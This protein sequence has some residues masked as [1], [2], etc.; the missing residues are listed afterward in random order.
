MAYMILARHH[1]R[2]QSTVKNKALLKAAA[3]SNN[4]TL[5]RHYLE[6]TLSAP[7]SGAVPVPGIK[8]VLARKDAASVSESLDNGAQREPETVF[9]ERSQPSFEAP[10]GKELEA[11]YLEKTPVVESV[12]AVVPPLPEATASESVRPN[13]AVAES[14]ASRHPVDSRGRELPSSPASLDTGAV[15]SISE[16]KA[17]QINWF[18]NMRI[19]LRTGKYRSLG[20]RIRASMAQHA[21]QLDMQA[22]EA[23]SRAISLQ[24]ATPPAQE[25]NVPGDL[26]K[27]SVREAA[28]SSI[29]PTGS[30]QPVSTDAPAPGSVDL[31]AT[32]PNEATREDPGRS[33]PVEIRPAS[34]DSVMTDALNME[35]VSPDVADE[36]PAAE[37][38][39]YQKPHSPAP[40]ETE[41][42][43]DRNFPPRPQSSKSKTERPAEAE[44]EY[45]I[46]AFSSFTFL[47]GDS[48]EEAEE[49]MDSG[50]GIMEAVAFQASA[51]N[52]GSGEI[53]F[54][55]NDRLIQISVS[56]EALAKYFKGRLPSEQPVAFGE[57]KIELDQL[58]YRL[59]DQIYDKG[60]SS[61]KPRE[62]ARTAS[63]QPPVLQERRPRVME[64]IDNFIENEPGI[65]R[66]M[67]TEST[68]GD[69]AK[70]SSHLDDH[71]VT[72]T[73]ARI[74]EKQGNKTKAIKIYE[75]LRL[76]F[77]EKSQ[78][79]V[80]LIEKLKQ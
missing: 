5:L 9:G 43:L 70:E 76:R 74:Y 7:R 2:N 45:E 26:E 49:V 34:S 13:D 56:R 77:P 55:E 8:P 53:I 38:V 42:S 73:L 15:V 63:H 66:G 35:A 58:E 80:H 20:G 59:S 10:A 78:Y 51:L 72:E 46:G 23:A 64:L 62:D 75:R 22:A 57:F 21:P 3:F 52:D 12:A 1:F 32:P 33:V 67:A 6:D 24:G 60:D 36:R 79:F 18:L 50:I 19:T 27:Q 28:P 61:A 25:V 4:R 37:P 40:V 16:P 11:S 65:S 41:P 44:K 69:L 47:S 30:A 39:V 17:G 68:S 54:E 71:W 29:H 14:V 31:T 48:K